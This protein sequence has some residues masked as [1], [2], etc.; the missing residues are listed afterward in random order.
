MFQRCETLRYSS[1]WRVFFEQTAQAI[2]FLSVELI[3]QW[4]QPKKHNDRDSHRHCGQM[5]QDGAT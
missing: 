4:C 1:M 5:R 2:G 3:I